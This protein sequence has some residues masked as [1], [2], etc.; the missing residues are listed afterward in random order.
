MSGEVE[1]WAGGQFQMNLARA[2]MQRPGT[3][4]IALGYDVAAAGCGFKRALPSPQF[5]AARAGARAHC[6]GS[7]LIENNVPAAGVGF[8]ASSN[9]FGMNGSAAGFGANVSI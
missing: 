4:G 2:G 9:S 5:H 1:G 3:G 8:E 6:A 7:R